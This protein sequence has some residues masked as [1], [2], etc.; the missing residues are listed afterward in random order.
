MFA[1]GGVALGVGGDGD[2]CVVLKEASIDQSV[3]SRAEAF[4]AIRFDGVEGWCGGSEGAFGGEVRFWAR[5]EED[6]GE[7][8]GTCDGG[9]VEADGSLLDEV[10]PGLEVFAGF[11]HDTVTEMAF[12]ALRLRG[13]ASNGEGDGAH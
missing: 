1:W 11:D 13:H 6:A 8:D 5:E 7:G 9:M 2:A 10:A 3:F 4:R 12:A